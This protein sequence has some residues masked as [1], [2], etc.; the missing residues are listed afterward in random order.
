MESELHKKVI[1]IHIQN[2][3]WKKLMDVFSQ[4]R[5]L[6]VQLF[7]PDHEVVKLID[8]ESRMC[9][10]FIQNLVNTNADTNKPYSN[11]NSI[12]NDQIALISDF[13]RK[14][15]IES[16]DCNG[17]CHK[18]TLMRLMHFLLVLE[19]NGK[20]EEALIL[21]R[22]AVKDAR[23]TFGERAY[24]TK[25]FEHF[26]AKY[27]KMNYL[28]KKTGTWPKI[29]EVNVVIVTI[30]GIPRDRKVN[31][32]DVQVLKDH[33]DGIHY[34]VA[35]DIDGKRSKFKALPTNLLFT[36]NTKIIFQGLEKRESYMDRRE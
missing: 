12:L 22:D 16:K 1:P 5:A 13:Y 14:R 11:S 23:V 28:K 2:G 17:K 30:G 32:R 35:I 26:L 20:I 34:I 3:N 15:Y 19:T 8:E 24:E 36:N 4:Q 6:A 25:R 21:C 10:I 29:S 9:L 27:E 31:G 18:K 7:G 33:K